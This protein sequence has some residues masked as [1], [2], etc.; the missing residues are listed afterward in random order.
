MGGTVI[1]LAR[2]SLKPGCGMRGGGCGAGAGG[3]EPSL[4]RRNSLDIARPGAG[5]VPAGVLEI[6]SNEVRLSRM[7]TRY[8]QR[9]ETGRSG[10][11]HLI[12]RTCATHMLENGAGIRFI[13]QLLGHEKLETTSIYTESPRRSR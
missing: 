3:L 2:R 7:V 13:Q 10:S 9:A 1:E 5:S 4:T 11:C 12:R 8:I 6:L